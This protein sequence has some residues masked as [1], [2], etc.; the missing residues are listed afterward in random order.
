MVDIAPEPL[1][2]V[3]AFGNETM[4]VWIPFEI[5]A[6]G[7]KDHD[8]TGSEIHGFVLLE[9]HAGDDTVYGMEEAVKERAVLQEEIPE[10]RINGKNTMPVSD[11][12]Q[13][14]GHRGSAL[15]GVEIPTGRTETAVAAERDEF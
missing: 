7:V 3:A 9:K 2:T 13:F 10:L 12:D 14:K 8:K 1:V 11:I 6:K 4:D 15:H 5:P